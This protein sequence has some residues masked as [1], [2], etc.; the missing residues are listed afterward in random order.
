MNP[1]T[2]QHLPYASIVAGQNDRTV[3]RADDLESLAAS[4]QAD[5][6]IQPITVRPLPGNR[7]EIVA[8]ERRYR[9]IGLLGWH[10]VPAIVRDLTD[11]QASTIMLLENVHRVDIDPVD[12]ARAYQSRIDRF[13]WTPAQVARKANVSARRV[14]ARLGLLRLV[15]DIARLVQ[16]GIIGIQYAEEMCDL[17]VNRQ[18]IA[19]RYLNSSEKPLLR[20]FRAVCAKLRAEQAQECL[21]DLESF[22]VQT[23]ATHEAERSSWQKQVFPV[24]PTVPPMQRAGSIGLS[25][26]TYI[27]QLMTSGD[28]RLIALAGIVGS[29]YQSLLQ[30]GMAYPPHGP[31]PLRTGLAVRPNGKV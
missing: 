30:T 24:D 14:S 19:F 17:D 29:I 18:R 20:E 25:F 1:P 9:A 31:S 16:Q 6:L 13:G 4:I 12:E 7:F 21:F 23:I 26:E 28:E 5:G 22:F 15:D 8:G 27:H 11:E 2:I 3:F 10:E